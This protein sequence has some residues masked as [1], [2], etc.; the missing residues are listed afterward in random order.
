MFAQDFL[1]QI[2]TEPTKGTNILDLCFSSHSSSRHQ[3]RIVPGLSDHDAIFMDMLNYDPRNKKP[4]K[5]VYCYNKA[6]W[7]SLHE[8]HAMSIFKAM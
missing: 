4:N 1:E 2:I 8:K 5:K 3:Y 6:D 7:I